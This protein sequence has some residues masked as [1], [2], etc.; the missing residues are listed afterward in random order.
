MRGPG[1]P[2]ACRDPEPNMLEVALL[3]RNV[4]PLTY[5]MKHFKIVLCEGTWSAKGLKIV[6]INIYL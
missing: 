4:F 2:R 3:V 5:E 6:T 1:Q